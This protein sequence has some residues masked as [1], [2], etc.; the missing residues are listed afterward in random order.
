VTAASRELRPLPRSF[1]DRTSTEVAADLLGRLLV[2]AVSGEPRRVARIVECEA[3]REDDPASHSYR[4]PTA[5][6]GVMFGLPGHLYVYF[7]YGMHFCMNVVTEGRGVGSAVL[8]RA[9]EPLSGLDAMAAARGVDDPRRLC[10]GPARLTQAF[11][12]TREQDGVDLTRGGELFVSAGTPVGPAATAVGPRIGIRRAIER[13][14]RFFVRDSPFVS[15][16]RD[17]TARRGREREQGSATETVTA[18]PPG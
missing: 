11:G 3:Y 10:S 7:T 14:W 18:R 6:N 16:P 15:G 12:V 17:A 1:Y 9:A 2:R 4:G 8:L 13:P 5:R